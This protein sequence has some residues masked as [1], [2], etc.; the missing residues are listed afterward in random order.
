[1]CALHLGVN[2]YSAQLLII[3]SGEQSLLNTKLK[4]AFIIIANI[5]IT[6]VPSAM[7]VH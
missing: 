5:S 7:A 1:M 2:S 6:D 3:V 4:R